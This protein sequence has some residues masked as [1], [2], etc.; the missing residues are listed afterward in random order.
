M[1]LDL[2]SEFVARD[3]HEVFPLHCEAAIA[4][5]CRVYVAQTIVK[6]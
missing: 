6:P 3:K 4:Y 5:C 1:D 2:F